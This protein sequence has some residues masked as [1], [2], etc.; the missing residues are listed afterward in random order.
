MFYKWLKGIFKPARDDKNNQDGR[1]QR[2]KDHS[3][4]D[5]DDTATSLSSSLEQ[6]ILTMKSAFGRSPDFVINEIKEIN[7]HALPAA[8]CFIEGLID[9]AQLIELMEANYSC[10][11]CQ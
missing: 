9:N 2:H 1:H 10:T 7:G 6:N 4:K 5:R 8:I 3:D 11:L